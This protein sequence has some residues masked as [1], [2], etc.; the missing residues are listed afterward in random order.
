[1]R[2]VQLL[3]EDGEE[4]HINTTDLEMD[5][6]N[7]YYPEN[8]LNIYLSR[9]ESI[10]RKS[11]IALGFENLDIHDVE[12]LELRLFD[13]G[14]LTRRPLVSLGQFNGE[15]ITIKPSC[16][17]IRSFE[18][19]YD[20]VL[21]QN[22][23]LEKD[24]SKN[25]VNYPTEQFQDYQSCDDSFQKEFLQKHSP[26]K[27]FWAFGKLSNKE[28]NHPYIPSAHVP[29]NLLYTGA[30]RSPCPLPCTTTVARTKFRFEKTS[31]GTGIETLNWVVFYL[32]DEVRVT[33]TLFMDTSV[34]QVLSDMGGTLGLWLGLGVLQLF[35]SF[36]AF[37]Y[38]VAK[39]TSA[40][41]V[42]H[43]RASEMGK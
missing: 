6:T 36:A 34:G 22:R 29:V 38:N 3:A 31:E 19:H 28:P 33:E 32:P 26:Y 9:F 5:I 24:K 7:P 40:M 10:Q 43:D 1:M 23:F 2:F 21:D 35:Q 8:V 25:C 27:P 20:V 37:K 42:N 11:T 30:K 16:K 15:L 18:Y 14:L 12:K 13:R 4:I 17:P 39:K 41:I